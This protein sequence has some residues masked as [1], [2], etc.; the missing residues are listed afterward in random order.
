MRSWFLPLTFL[1]CIACAP[2]APQLLE[3]DEVH[4]VA[5]ERHDELVVSGDGF[6]EHAEAQ[7]VFAGTAHRAGVGPKDVAISSRA[8]VDSRHSLRVAMTDELVAEFLGGEARHA[9]FR[10]EISVAFAPRT[11]GAP[12]VSGR[13][14][15]AVLDLFEVTGEGPGAD[16]RAAT[17]LVADAPLVPTDPDAAR[18]AEQYGW[19]LTRNASGSMCVRGLTDG[20]APGPVAAEDCFERFAD[21]NV[22]AADD[23][24]P[25]PSLREAEVLVR[26]PGFVEPIALRVDVAGIKPR[27][28]GA[29]MWALVGVAI[30][31]SLLLLGRTPLATGLALVESKLGRAL[32]DPTRSASGSARAAPSLLGGLLPFLA[33]STLFAGS[34]LGL[35][36]SLSEFDLLLVFCSAAVLLGLAQFLGGGLGRRSW[37]IGRAILSVL[38]GTAVHLTVLLALTAAVMQHASLSLT[39]TASGQ[40]GL[41]WNYT[42]FRSLGSYLAGAALL[43]TIALLGLVRFG[44]TR[45]SQAGRL[46]LTRVLVD[47]YIWSLSGLFVAVY[48]GGWEVPP[49]LMKMTGS[50][51][52]LKLL[53]FQL[54]LTSLFALVSWLRQVLPQ[55]DER[56]LTPVF[57]R[58]LLPLTALGAVLDLVWASGSWPDWLQSASTAAL[59]SGSVL[60]LGGLTARLAI[61]RNAAPTT[62]SVN[63]WL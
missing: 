35:P 15:D 38:R 1:V 36:G 11:P 46:R 43:C 23:L 59:L 58:W 49:A 2:A 19:Q 50:L 40:G 42:L 9:T 34:G 30:L 57:R 45:P 24:V 52:T 51:A 62:V 12:P 28:P 33:A 18:L 60:L 3:V 22:Y 5:V 26:R 6:S 21:V 25:T 31:A 17:G 61:G 20:A 7:V 44:R 39:E 4:P 14:S 48:L 27:N 55:I 54:K 13:L 16:A 10:G 53:C 56:T 29:W 32:Q 41:P 37:S 47:T 63:P 8:V